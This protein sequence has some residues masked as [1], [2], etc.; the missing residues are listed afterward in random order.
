MG[1]S[2]GRAILGTL[3]VFASARGVVDGIAQQT[4]LALSRGERRE[5]IFR[6]QE[7]IQTMSRSELVSAV[8]GKVPKSFGPVVRAI[9]LEASTYGIKTSF[10]LAIAL[11]VVCFLLARKLPAFPSEVPAP[12]DSRSSDA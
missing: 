7:M 11:T 4:G 2:L 6:L 10:L 1:S 12:A 9:E 8:M 5:L 3:F